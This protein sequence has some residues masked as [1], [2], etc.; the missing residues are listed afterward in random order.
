MKKTAV[1]AWL[2]ALLVT[3]SACGVP[4]LPDL[5]DVRAFVARVTFTRSFPFVV[6]AEADEPEATVSVYRLAAAS[7]SGSLIVYETFPASDPRTQDLSGL[8]GLLA[9][10]AGTE[11]LSCALP[12]GVTVEDWRLEGGVVSLTLSPEFLGLNELRK[13]AAA[14]CAVLTLCQLDGVE[15]VAVVSGGQTVFPYLTPDDAVLTDEEGDPY[16]RRLR[17]YFPDS[18][19]R[20]LISEYHTLSLDDDADLARCVVEEL[21]RGPNNAELRPAVPAGTALRSCV[22]ADGLCTVDLSAAFYDNRPDTALGERL[23]LCALANSLTALSGVKAVRVLV[24]GEPVDVYVYRTLTEPLAMYDA[25]VGP[26]SAPL[27]EIDAD[28]YLALPGLAGVTPL[29]FRVSEAVGD[30]LAEA[31][32]D[33]LLSAEEPGY[34]ALFSGS[35]TVA[36]VTVRGGVCAVELSE[37]FF[38]SLPADA[39]PLAVQSIAETLRA[40]PGIAAVTFSVNGAPAVYDGMDFSVYNSINIEVP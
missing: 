31:V 6:L 21:L 34:P 9:A 1:I 25:A 29:P 40:L 10:P 7:G 5:A 26:V 14:F 32:L 24:E 17:L 22:T 8:I 38:V 23:T 15:A 18:E 33:R 3:L 37:S 30:S 4:A 16:T 12:D 35:G 36:G 39:A 2:L 11:G 27:G 20:Y 19:G 13:S 28:L